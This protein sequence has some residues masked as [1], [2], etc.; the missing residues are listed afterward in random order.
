MRVGLPG[1]VWPMLDERT[2]PGARHERREHHRLPIVDLC[3]AT[4]PAVPMGNENP[5]RGRHERE[6]RHRAGRL[7]EEPNPVLLADRRQ[8][9]SFEYGPPHGLVEKQ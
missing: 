4:G 7:A 6:A 1:R 3:V 2:H 8:L 9:H 5:D